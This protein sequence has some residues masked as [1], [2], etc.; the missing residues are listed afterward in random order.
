MVLPGTHF[1]W[2]VPM[3]GVA[4]FR[5]LKEHAGDI[6]DGGGDGSGGGGGGSSSATSAGARKKPSG[7]EV[8]M[9]VMALA[10]AGEYEQILN[11]AGGGLCHC[12]RF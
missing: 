2:F 12:G 9:R 10:D 11:L 7:K 8:A 3:V 5:Y 6:G 1:V 4:N